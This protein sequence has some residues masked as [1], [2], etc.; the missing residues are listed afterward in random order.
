MAAVP[1]PPPPRPSGN[2][3]ARIV[4]RSNR[5]L[6]SAMRSSR[7]PAGKALAQFNFAFQP[8]VKR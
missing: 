5:R 1:P 3:A 2:C 8:G 4:R 7:L 6:D